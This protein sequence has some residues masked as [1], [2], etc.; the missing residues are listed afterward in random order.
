[1]SAD[2]I[3]IVGGYGEVGRRLAAQ[4]EATQHGIVPC[5]EDLPAP[6]RGVGATPTAGG[7]VRLAL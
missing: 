7:G 1:M 3:L 2:N 6:L 4:L 5:I